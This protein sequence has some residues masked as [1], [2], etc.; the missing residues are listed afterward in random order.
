M[1]E[2]LFWCRHPLVP[3]PFHE[4]ISLHP[5]SF[6]EMIFPLVIYIGKECG[7]CGVERCLEY[8]LQM[9]DINSFK[10]GNEQG[11]L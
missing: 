5:P 9:L 1:N 7:Q 11:E 6:R 10:D 8:T 2:F 3:L 4:V